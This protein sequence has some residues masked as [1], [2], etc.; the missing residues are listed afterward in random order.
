MKW[1]L[2]QYSGRDYLVMSVFVG[3]FTISVNSLMLGAHY[4]T[5]YRVFL[6]ATAAAAI[7][8]STGFTACSAVG[9]LLKR[10]FKG[11]EGI[12]LRLLVMLFLFLIIIVI[13]LEFLFQGYKYIPFFNYTFNKTAFIWSLIGTGIKRHL[14][15]LSARRHSAVPDLEE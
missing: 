14:Y 9:V 15:N 4:F 5:D 12:G 8:Y 3:P 1:K 13:F 10:F 11:E 7:V 2:P 6:T